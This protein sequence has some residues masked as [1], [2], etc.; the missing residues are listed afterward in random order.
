MTARLGLGRPSQKNEE[1]REINFSVRGDEVGSVQGCGRC[2]E[3]GSAL[4]CELL[5]QEKYVVDIALV[6][7]WSDCSNARRRLGMKNSHEKLLYGGQQVDSRKKTQAK[8]RK[9][10][11]K[12]KKKKKK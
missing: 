8:L 2:N 11:N 9:G 6:G 7:L 4:E 1:K 12:K 10:G 5:G 3:Q